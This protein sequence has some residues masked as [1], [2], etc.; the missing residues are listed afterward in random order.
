MQVNGPIVPPVYGVR[1]SHIGLSG[2]GNGWLL[3]LRWTS[4]TATSA[5]GTG[6]TNLNNCKPHL[7]SDNE[8]CSA[9]GRDLR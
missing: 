2:D 9:D 4:W 3:G 8:D 5:R 7:S 1:P 6:Y